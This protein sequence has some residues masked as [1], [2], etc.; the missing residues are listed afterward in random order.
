MY[1]VRRVNAQPP[2]AEVTHVRRCRRLNVWILV[3]HVGAA[4]A[5][6]YG[7]RF[8]SISVEG[9]RMTSRG[10]PTASC[11]ARRGFARSVA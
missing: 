3:E 5:L 10:S 4:G 2:F 1:C 6:Y 8:D 9:A 7:A 11:A